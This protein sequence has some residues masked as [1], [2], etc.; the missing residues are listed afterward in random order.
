MLKKNSRAAGR[1]KPS[2]KPI[3]RRASRRSI[4]RAISA[5]DDGATLLRVVD[6]AAMLHVNP[7]TVWRWQKTGLFPPPLTIG[8]NVKAWTL[9]TI[10]E[11]IATREAAGSQSPGRNSRMK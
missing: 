6:V 5:T 3:K 8:P 10:R 9:G 11:W 2:D 1:R 7:I 4:P